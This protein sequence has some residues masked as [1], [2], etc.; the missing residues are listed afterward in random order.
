MAS[1]PANWRSI[2]QFGAQLDDDS[3]QISPKNWTNHFP[4]HARHRHETGQSS[5]KKLNLGH[6][7]SYRY[8]IYVTVFVHIP[9]GHTD[10][11]LCMLMLQQSFVHIPETTMLLVLSLTRTGL[12]GGVPVQPRRLMIFLLRFLL[13]GAACFFFPLWRRDPA[14]QL[15]F[16]LPCR[17]KF[18]C[19]KPC[20]VSHL[21]C[22]KASCIQPCFV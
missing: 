5:A 2:W 6:I 15:H 16:L 22:L 19:V 8:I 3:E 18:H 1:G 7:M 9:L 21:L 13:K 17:L 14:L 4:P 12:G 20:F 11:W 10:I